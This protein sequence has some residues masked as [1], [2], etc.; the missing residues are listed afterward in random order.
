MKRFGKV[1]LTFG[2]LLLVLAGCTNNMETPTSKVEEFLGKYQ[3][4]DSDVTTQLDQVLE[5]EDT[6]TDEQKKEYRSL[7]EKQYQNLSY[8]INN[9]D[10]DG[11]TATVDVEIEVLDYASTIQDAKKYYDE[12]KD[13]IEEEYQKDK[14]DND[15]VVEDAVDGAENAVKESAAYIDYKIKELKSA[16]DTVNYDITFHLLKE[17][18]EWKIQD[19]S[20]TDLEKIHGLYE[21]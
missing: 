12:H 14:E 6:M 10:V 3:N 21:G 17:D 13:E 15:N 19:I 5:D 7:L 9:E 18:G 20:D 16:T 1:V 11:D 4:L 2:F 8:K